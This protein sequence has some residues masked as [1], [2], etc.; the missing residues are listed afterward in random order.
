MTRL[1]SSYT[2]LLSRSVYALVLSL[3]VIHL[4]SRVDF[5]ESLKNHGPF[6]TSRMSASPHS[7]RMEFLQRRIGEHSAL[8]IFLDS[9]FDAVLLLK[10]FFVVNRLMTKGDRSGN[11]ER[12]E[13]MG[14]TKQQRIDRHMGGFYSFAWLFKDPYQLW[15]V[16]TWRFYDIVAVDFSPRPPIAS[17]SIDV[18]LF[19]S[20]RC[21][22]SS[23]H[24]G[25]V[26]SRSAPL[27]TTR[28]ESPPEPLS[29]TSI[30]SAMLHWLSRSSTTSHLMVCTT[31][32]SPECDSLLVQCS[33]HMLTK[34]YSLDYHLL[35]RPM[36]IELV[37][38]PGLAQSAPPPTQAPRYEYYA[39]MPSLMNALT[40][41][42][43]LVY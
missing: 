38:A 17:V 1:Q 32:H 41:T 15:T 8:F 11:G 27:C 21:S 33:A 10:P 9:L 19:Y 2:L 29:S 5:I 6:R 43:G 3:L 37:I 40:L 18:S 28:T 16:S 39:R 26:L 25:L 31:F 22:S 24:P 30:A 14:A 23:F 34:R 7:T 35:G 4:S 42:E 20:P 36:K 13:R 12:E